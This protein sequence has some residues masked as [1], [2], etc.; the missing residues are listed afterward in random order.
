MLWCSR[1]AVTVQTVVIGCFLYKRCKD[2]DYCRT[3][4]RQ[5]AL[6]LGVSPVRLGDPHYVRDVFLL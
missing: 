3:F 1:L 5:L 6:N 4:L 2:S